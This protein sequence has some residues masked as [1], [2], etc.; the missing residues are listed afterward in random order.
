MILRNDLFVFWGVHIDE[1]LDRS[2]FDDTK[3]VALLYKKFARQIEGG[4][5]WIVKCYKV[6]EYLDF[7]AGR[8]QFA[9]VCSRRG[10]VS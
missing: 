9:G 6:F 3:C 2:R 4:G 10:N 7:D 1:K 5:V 8:R